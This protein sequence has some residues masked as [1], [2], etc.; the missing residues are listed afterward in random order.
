[1]VFITHDMDEALALADRIIVLHG[2]PG[3]VL[4][5]FTPDLS[6]PV[7]RTSIEFFAWKRRLTALFSGQMA[8]VPAAAED[9]AAAE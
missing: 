8:N 4:A 2:P 7:A 1:M 9:Q 3:R 5:D 6:R